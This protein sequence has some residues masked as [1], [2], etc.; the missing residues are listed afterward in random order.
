[1][2]D[3]GGHGDVIREVKRDAVRSV[4]WHSACCCHSLLKQPVEGC[5]KCLRGSA[6]Q[7]RVLKEAT[8]GNR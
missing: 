3:A 7:D 2:K 1:V 5:Q 4:I 6:D 8:E